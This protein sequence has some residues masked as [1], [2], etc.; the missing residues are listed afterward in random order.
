MFRN[1]VIISV[2]FV[3]TG[4]SYR[5]SPVECIRFDKHTSVT[6]QLLTQKV[7]SQ[8]PEFSLSNYEDSFTSRQQAAGELWLVMRND[9]VELSF[10]NHENRFSDVCAYDHS[11]GDR[12]KQA[13]SALE[14]VKEML[15]KADVQFEL[16]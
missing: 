10:R 1:L 15:T 14:V 9:D 5:L 13:I 12:T 3:D 6:L 2:I 7:Q 4:C 11:G 16:L 8:E